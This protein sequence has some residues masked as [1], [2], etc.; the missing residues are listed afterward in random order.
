MSRFESGET[1]GVLIVHGAP[2]A[3]KGT[4]SARFSDE[5]PLARHISAG[6]TIRSIFKGETESA[7]LE[8]MQQFSKANIVFPGDLSADIMFD[9]MESEEDASLYLIDGFPQRP[10]ELEALLLN[11]ER[12]KLKILGT[13]CLEVD[14]ITSVDRMASRG[15]RDGESLPWDVDI[16]SYYHHRYERFMG[17]YSSIKTLIAESMPIYE[18]DA[19]KDRSTVYGDFADTVARAIV[20]VNQSV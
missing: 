1:K 7:R 13:I 5:N 9:A 6:D 14:A 20:K 4:A 15:P 11:A 10:D 16:L 19:N 3:G 12:K 2:G 8:E 18:I 17:Y